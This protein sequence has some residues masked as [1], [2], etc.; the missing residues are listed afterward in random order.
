VPRLTDLALKNLA[1]PARGHVTYWDRPLGVRVSSTGA[2]T[3]IVILHSGRRHKIGRY[4]DITLAQAREAAQ[5]LKAEK[6]LGRIFPVSVSLAEAREQYLLHADIRQNTRIYYER[7][8]HRL[9][10]SKLANIT[11][12]DINQAVAGLKPTSRTQ[13]LASLR[14]FFRWCA[15]PPQNYLARSPL[16]GMQLSG[17][18][19]RKRVLDDAELREVWRAAVAQGYPHGTVVQLLILTG[20]RRGEVA[21]LRRTWIDTRERTITLPEWITKNGR[22]HTFPYGDLVT[23]ILDTIPIRN[24]TALLFPSRDAEDRPL[25]GWSKFKHELTDEV[26]GWRLHDLRRTYRTTHARIGTPPHIGERLINHASG[27]TSDVEAI[28]DRWTYLPDMRKAV[29]SH[30]THIRQVLEI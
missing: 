22:T 3:F 27:V 6:T 20:Q 26:A 11:M 5:T 13:A 25:S 23:A 7:S 8:L 10:S 15:R 4:G 2:K 9:K 30:E 17:H 14:A 28:Y 29:A 21:N 1:L 24:S 18:K 16:E 19:S 12:R